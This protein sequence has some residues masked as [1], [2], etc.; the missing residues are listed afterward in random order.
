[1]IKYVFFHPPM[2]SYLTPKLLRRP[3]L[4]HA[5]DIC[6]HHYPVPR[7]LHTIKN[8]IGTAYAKQEVKFLLLIDTSERRPADT[9]PRYAGA[10]SATSQPPTGWTPKLVTA[11]DKFVK[12]PRSCLTLHFQ[13]TKTFFFTV[14]IIYNVV[15]NRCKHVEPAGSK[16]H[17]SLV[18][19]RVT[20][21]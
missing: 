10:G 2:R 12:E 16:D 19:G 14:Y 1:M 15:E 17:R 18:S 9:K 21:A 13:L 4:Y 7:V 8:R 20:A 3:T 6:P 5:S 11:F